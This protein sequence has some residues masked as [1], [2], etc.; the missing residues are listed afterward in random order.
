MYH[1]D[2]VN[3]DYLQE[4][5]EAYSVDKYA[6]AFEDTNS[7]GEHD[8]HFHIFY[9]TYKKNQINWEKHIVEKYKLRRKGRGGVIKYGTLKNIR[10]L[11]KMLSYTLKNEHFRSSGFS[12]EELKFAVEQSFKKSDSKLINE[13]ILEQLVEKDLK[14][15]SLDKLRYEI[16]SIINTPAN[17]QVPLSKSRVD[18]IAVLYMR[19]VGLESHFGPVSQN[20]HL[21][22]ILYNKDFQD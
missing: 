7:K 17:R 3:F 12:E 18:T 15:Y 21:F 10:D 16:I 19:D 20:C 4:S 1:I 13:R 6:I 2:Y 22:E 5:L 8:P 11:D 14:I 9:E